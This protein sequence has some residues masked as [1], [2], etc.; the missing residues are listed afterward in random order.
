M[1]S[2]AAAAYFL[3]REELVN[4]GGKSDV[5]DEAFLDYINK[6]DTVDLNEEIALKIL[7][8]ESAVMSADVASSPSPLISDPDGYAMGMPYYTCSLDVY[9]KCVNGKRKTGRWQSHLDGDE[10]AEGIKNW[11][12]LNAKEGL[13]IQNEKTNAYTVLRRPSGP[14]R[15]NPHT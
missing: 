15:W 8:N 1:I 4:Q 12:K 3:L 6:D 14:G 11:A 9:H 7:V 10:R 2:K 5:I 13:M